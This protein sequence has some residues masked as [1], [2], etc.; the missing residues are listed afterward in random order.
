MLSFM[1]MVYGIP[2]TGFCQE[3]IRPPETEVHPTTDSN[4]GLSACETLLNRE[5]QA[6]QGRE[7]WVSGI[8]YPCT[9]G[10]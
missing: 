9:Q 3:A 8:T 7:K 2:E 5:F 10:S 4:H 6:G 1:L